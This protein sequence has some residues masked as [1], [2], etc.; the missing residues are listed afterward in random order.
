MGSPAVTRSGAPRGARGASRG[1]CRPP[2]TTARL[3]GAQPSLPRP[4][5]AVPTGVVADGRRLPT[6][7]AAGTRLGTGSPSL[8]VSDGH[9]ES[10]GALVEMVTSP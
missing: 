4:S 2:L 5:V 1:A 7:T 9:I 3:T 8:V 6:G 10:V